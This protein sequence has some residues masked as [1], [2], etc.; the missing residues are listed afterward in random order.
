MSVRVGE[1]VRGG[2][3]ESVRRIDGLPKVTGAFAYASDLWAE[4]LLWG[5]TL[6]SPHPH[7]RIRG[8]QI[9]EAVASPGV[10]AVLLADD[11]PGERTFGLDFADQP[12]LAWDRVRYQG[13]P[14][15]LVAAEHPELARRAGA[16][17]RVDY[18]ELPAVTDMERAL[19]PGTPRLHDLGNVLRHVRIVHGDPDAGADVWVDGYYETG[20]QD[21][22][23]LGPEA[24]LAV[25]SEDG[26][27]DLYVAT[28]WLHVDRQQ[29]APCLGLT[30][31]K[32]RIHLAGV[33]GAF[34]ARE[35]V[36]IQIHACLLALHTGRPVKMSY[37]R[38]ESFF[39]H[40][41]RHPFRM[42]FR[43][44][45]TRDGRLV[46]VRARLLAD[47]GAYS[48]SSSAVIGNASTFAV[49]PYEVPNALIEGTCVYTNNPP[50]GA[51]RG[52]GAVQVCFGHE[53]QM[54]RLAAALE[55]DPVELRLRNAVGPGSVL[56]T[57]QVIRGVA[58]VRELIERCAAASMPPE[59]PADGRDALSYPGGAG[60]VSRGEALRRGVGFAVGYK[61]VGYSEGFDD[62]S[63]AR[64]TLFRGT[65]GPAAEIHTA[66]AEVGQG[67]HTVIVQIARTELGT[68]DVILHPTDTLVGS[69]GSTSASR[70]TMMTGGAVQLAC[71]A[72]R[73][74]LFERA[75]RRAGTAPG[76]AAAVEEGWVVLEGERVA[77]VED[78]LDEPIAATR[79][80][81]HRPTGPLDERGQGDP[82]VTFAFAAMRAVAEVDADLG[83]VRVVQL[84][85]AQDVG[86]ALNPQAVEGQIEGGAAQ[87]LGLAL[88]EEIQLQDGA[89]RNASFTDY[90]I[91]TILDM[92]PVVSDLVEEPEPGVPFGAKG[93][94]EPSTIVATAAIVAALRDATGREL[95]RAPVKPDDLVGLSSPAR[96]AGAQLEHRRNHQHPLGRGRVLADQV[97]G[98]G[99]LGQRWARPHLDRELGWVRV[100]DRAE[101]RPRDDPERAPRR[102]VRVPIRRVGRR[103][104]AGPDRS[105]PDADPASRLR[106]VT[107]GPA[108]AAR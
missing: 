67:L 29:I 71:G 53:A 21:Q 2:V 16:K 42:W 91:P 76:T 48:S 88:M 39:G 18:E 22:A 86:T 9:G 10:H 8:I 41:H 23:P 107:R 73:E 98:G 82:H 7:A 15:A 26:G 51:M 40:V 63:E 37:G 43:H 90:L 44:G 52:F 45:A 99:W 12:V 94:G 3:G 20:M 85:A 36:S 61:N 87:G 102:H 75:R 70:Q 46:S 32:V 5:H 27:V 31:E 57:G 96:S 95:N 97:P 65:D 59:Q 93:V 106:P 58:P 4:R 68:P 62:S 50:C 74:Q 25:P 1:R 6:R 64:V 78:L 47:G 17:I 49:G 72:V 56:P 104:R 101:P 34:G 13:E 24:G 28:Q 11:V 92:P 19:E 69:G 55:M 66:A 89:V 54:D 83:L 81:H 77:R 14:V 38:E 84:A 108:A 103:R 105:C 80:Y 30:E 33:G 79:V 60:N 100:D 35:D